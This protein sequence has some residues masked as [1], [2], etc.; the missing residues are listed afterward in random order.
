MRAQKIIEDIQYRRMPKVVL[1]IESDGE[2]VSPVILVYIFNKGSFQNLLLCPE[3]IK[4]FLQASRTQL[5]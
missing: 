2:N 3:N 1:E 4:A 5:R